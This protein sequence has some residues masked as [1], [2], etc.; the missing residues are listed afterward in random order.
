MVC[1]H[2]P[3]KHAC[4]SLLVFNILNRSQHVYALP[5]YFVYIAFVWLVGF[6]YQSAHECTSVRTSKHHT[7]KALELPYI[8]QKLWP[9]GH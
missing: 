9:P 5:Q 4:M 1:S 8:I 7:Q 2:P 3:R 6:T